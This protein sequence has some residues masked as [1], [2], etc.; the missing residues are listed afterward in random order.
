MEARHGIV[1]VCGMSESGF[2]GFFDTVVLGLGVRGGYQYAV[3]VEVACHLQCSGQFGGCVPTADATGAFDE[4]AIFLFFNFLH[5]S[6]ELAACHLRVK[7]GPFDVQAEYGAAGFLHQLLA[8]GGCLVQLVEGGRGKGGEDTRGS[9]LQMSVDSG[10]EGFRGTFR[11]VVSATSV[12]VHTDE[13][14]DNVHAFGIYHPGTDECEVTVGHFE[15]LSIA[16]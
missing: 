12:S 13:A 14:G 5:Q 1:K 15:N 3:V 2:V 6:G 10:A 9:I 8:K 16:Y 4:F 7:V 11:K